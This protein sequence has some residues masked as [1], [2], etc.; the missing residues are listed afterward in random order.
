MEDME[1]EALHQGVMDLEVGSSLMGM[2]GDLRVGGTPSLGAGRISGL[3]PFQPGWGWVPPSWVPPLEI[4]WVPLTGRWMGTWMLG[5][6]LIC[7]FGW[8]S[9]G[10]VSPS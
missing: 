8:D 2:V 1:V 7:P 10:W 4:D 5:P 9:L 3:G 6:L